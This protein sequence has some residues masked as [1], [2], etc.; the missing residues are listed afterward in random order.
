MEFFDSDRPRSGFLR[1]IHEKNCKEHCKKHCYTHLTQSCSILWVPRLSDSNGEPTEFSD[2]S[3][4][5]IDRSSH[6]S[7]ILNVPTRVFEILNSLPCFYPKYRNPEESFSFQSFL[8][9]HMKPEDRRQR[10]E[11]NALS[12]PSNLRSEFQ[13]KICLWC[14]IFWMK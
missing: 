10:Q 4:K 12:K 8:A 3:S 2:N 5:Q 1:E 11:T 7:S 13:K 6:F 14:E 9:Y